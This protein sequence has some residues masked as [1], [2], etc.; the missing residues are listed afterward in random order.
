MGAPAHRGLLHQETAGDHQ[1]EWGAPQ[2]HP[3]L[4]PHGLLQMPQAECGPFQKE[5]VPGNKAGQGEWEKG[6]PRRWR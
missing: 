1:R 3:A 4:P 6:C 2:S 5:Q